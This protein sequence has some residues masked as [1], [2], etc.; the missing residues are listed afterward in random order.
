MPT[1]LYTGKKGDGLAVTDRM[2]A[3]SLSAAKYRLQLRGF[4]DLVFHTDEMTAK[5]DD[6]IQAEHAH[7]LP[8]NELSPEQE[9]EARH[10]GGVVG[11]IWF[12]WKANTLFWLPLFLWSGVAVWQGRPHGWLDWT[13][14]GLTGLFFIYFFWIVM[15]GVAYQKILESSV[16]HRWDELGRWVRVTRFWKRLAFVPIPEFEL[17][18]RIASGL[19]AMGKLEKA[20]QLVKKYEVHTCGKFQYFSRLSGLYEAA[21]DYQKMTECRQLAIDHGTGQPEEKLDLALGL[22]QRE[23]KT[24]PAKAIM[25]G[26]DVSDLSDLPTIFYEYCQGLLGIET[27]DWAGGEQRLRRTMELARPF[28]NNILMAGMMREASA[29]LSLALSSQGKLEEAEVLL[30]QAEPMLQARDEND[31]LQRCRAALGR[32]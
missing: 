15:P 1:F 10:G 25:D 29:Y 2:E 12:A 6:V 27:C 30:R 11:T 26:I 21:R 28:A 32:A 14:F 24:A 3:A 31:L 5:I 19:A 4:R 7:L 8:P 13:G 22:L 20:L 17:D 9:V 23:R 18:F 16:W